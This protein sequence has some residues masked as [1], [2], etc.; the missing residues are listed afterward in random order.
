MIAVPVPDA[1]VGF[2]DLV[3][4]HMDEFAFDGV[5]VPFVAFVEASLHL[6]GQF[7]LPR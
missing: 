1:V 7:R 2:V 5:R 3:G 6:I 4:A